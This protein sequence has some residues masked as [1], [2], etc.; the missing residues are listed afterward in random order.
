MSIRIATN[1]DIEATLD[2]RGATRENA[3]SRE[4]LAERGITPASLAVEFA[5][6]DH[7]CWVAESD[8]RVVGF[9]IAES[10][11]GEVIALAVRDG[12]E[13]RG[14]GRGLLGAAVAWLREQGVARPFLYTSPRS[15]WRAFHVYR[16]HGW[17]ATG[18]ALPNGDERLELFDDDQR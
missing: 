5:Q 11:H 13:G 4:R 15:D 8:G 9:C 17:R 12:C 16:D 14:F 2:V 18:H 6:P 1:A 7:R 10:K 3:I